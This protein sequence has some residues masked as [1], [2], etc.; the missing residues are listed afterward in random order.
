M[1]HTLERT[2]LGEAQAGDTVNLEVDILAKYVEKLVHPG[3]ITG[4]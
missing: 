4:A 1:P 2:T 3:T